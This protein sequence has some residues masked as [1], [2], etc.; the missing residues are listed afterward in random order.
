MNF[1]TF[2]WT[3]YCDN[4]QTYYVLNAPVIPSVSPLLLLMISMKV[5]VDQICG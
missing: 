5:C 2:Q 3:I 4:K 1:I